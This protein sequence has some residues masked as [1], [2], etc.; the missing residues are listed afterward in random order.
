MERINE[1]DIELINGVYLFKGV[2]PAITDNDEITSFENDD[3]KDDFNKSEMNVYDFA[4][5]IGC[6]YYFN[7]DNTSYNE[8][9]QSCSIYGQRD[10]NPHTVTYYM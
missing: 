6:R 9:N 1:N 10:Y 2:N 8:N 3:L 5:S 4:E 7:D